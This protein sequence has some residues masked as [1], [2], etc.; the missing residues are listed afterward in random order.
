[1]GFTRKEVEE[2]RDAIPTLYRADRGTGASLSDAM[3]RTEIEYAVADARDAEAD[4]IAFIEAEGAIAMAQA[5]AGSRKIETLQDLR[6]L[7]VTLEAMDTDDER[8][9]A[10]AGI[11]S[12]RMIANYFAFLDKRRAEAQANERKSRQEAH[13]MALLYAQI[14]ELDFQIGQLE[15]ALDYLARTGDVEGTMEK[16]G[17]QDA[18]AKWEQRTGRKFDPNSPEGKQI[19]ED[20]IRE[21]L[22]EKR[23]QKAEAEREAGIV[24]AGIDQ[25]RETKARTDA[26]YA[27][28]A[29]TRSGR[30]GL[31]TDAQYHERER[32]LNSAVQAASKVGELEHRLLTLTDL[33]QFKGTPNYTSKIDDF[34]ASADQATVS[35]IYND[36]NSDPD[37]RTRIG[38]HYLRKEIADMEEFKGT[39]DYP[40]YIQALIADAPESVR[41]AMRNEA[42]L[43]ETV[44]TALYESFSD[45]LDK[46]ESGE[47][48]VVTAAAQPEADD[49]PASPSVPRQPNQPSPV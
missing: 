28:Q 41:E 40:A 6:D 4:K 19:L 22:R 14:A 25:E 36:S 49:E 16:P 35:D 37:I 27:A 21:D 29:E 38:L 9:N 12:G 33:E 42:D 43:D 5:G 3:R 7:A 45:T 23:Q 1:M 32:T 13:Y 44:A 17:V 18:V 8:R 46:P 26:T 15:D 30:D 47:T 2:K 20:I 10:L 34:V 11:V 39:P 48:P 24:N 31:I